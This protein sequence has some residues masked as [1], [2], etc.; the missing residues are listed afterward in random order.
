[1]AQL[2]GTLRVLGV[3]VNDS[4]RRR[5]NGESGQTAAEYMGIVVIVAIIIAAI[6]GSGVGTTFASDITTKIGEF[7]G[8]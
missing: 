7:F 6:A 8:H 5:V 3:T 1:M 4:I 2:I